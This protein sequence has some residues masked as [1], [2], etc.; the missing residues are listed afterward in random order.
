MTE[1]AAACAIGM[2]AWLWLGDGEKL[3]RLYPAVAVLLFAGFLTFGVLSGTFTWG[4]CARDDF[5]GEC[6]PDLDRP[7][8]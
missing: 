3:G 1:A 5:T 2:L 8:Y 7:T 6:Y 4:S